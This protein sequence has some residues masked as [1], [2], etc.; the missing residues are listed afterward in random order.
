MQF[1]ILG[2]DYCQ[3]CMRAKELLKNKKRKF[4]FLSSNDVDALNKYGKSIPNDYSFIPKILIVENN[5]TKFLGGYDELEKHLEK[6]KHKKQSNKS[7]PSKKS[8]KSNK[9][10]PSKKSK[11]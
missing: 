5:K 10:K 11:K 6:V 8:K 9:S 3:W 7:K 4:K 2:Q 1:I